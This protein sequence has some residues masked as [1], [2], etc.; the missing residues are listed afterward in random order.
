MINIFT[1]IDNT[2]Q[3][4]NGMGMNNK[5]KKQNKTTIPDDIPIIWVNIV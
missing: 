1:N 5:N 3:Y 4:S 2:N